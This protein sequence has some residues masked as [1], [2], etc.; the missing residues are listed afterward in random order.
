VIEK[1][2]RLLFNGREVLSE[3]ENIPYC[4]VQSTFFL[5]LLPQFA[6]PPHSQFPMERGH[7]QERCT[8]L[9]HFR[10]F[11]PGGAAVLSLLIEW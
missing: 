10:D 6:S 5:Y 3:G 1:Y 8:A 7:V 11:W 4:T 2:F 9:G